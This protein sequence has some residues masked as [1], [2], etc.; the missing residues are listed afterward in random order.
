MP[1]RAREA[2]AALRNLL[3]QIEEGAYLRR[4]AAAVG[5]RGRAVVSWSKRPE[6]SAFA[7]RHRQ[8]RPHGWNRARRRSGGP[9]EK[10]SACTRGP[11]RQLR[12]DESNDQRGLTSALSLVCVSYRVCGVAP[13]GPLGAPTA[14]PVVPAGARTPGVSRSSA[15]AAWIGCRRR[16]GHAELLPER[17]DDGKPNSSGGSLARERGTRA[18]LREGRGPSARY[19]ARAVPDRASR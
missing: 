16:L 2:D 9:R 6:G 4:G 17:R 11:P 10:T 13:V 15:D 7:D 5:C 19:P 12:G 8:T 3:R 18:T 14:R 1:W